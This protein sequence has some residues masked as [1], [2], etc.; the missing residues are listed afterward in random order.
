MSFP[1]GLYVINNWI[2]PGEEIEIIQFLSKNEWSDDMSKSRPTQ[3]FGYKYTIS[4]YSSSTEKLAS[5]WGPL[6]KIANRLEQEFAE[7]NIKIAQALAN[8]YYKDSSIGAHVDK[9]APLVFGISLI[10][11]INMDW[12]SINDSKKKYRLL[13]PRF[14][15][16]IMSGKSATEWKHS[17]PK[18][19][20]LYYTDKTI[21]KPNDYFRISI[22]FRHFYNANT[23]KEQMK[24]DKSV[25]VIN[26]FK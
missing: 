4:G 11:D 18:L 1:Q 20:K 7:W 25:T 14:S 23:L 21:D 2:T 9:E 15:L 6:Q 5:D 17:V 22:T 8:M 19:S 26:T 13:I 16:Y 10:N 3:H 24:N 12:T